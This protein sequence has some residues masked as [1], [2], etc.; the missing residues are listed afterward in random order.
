MSAGARAI[1]RENDTT[2]RKANARG[3]EPPPRPARSPVPAGPRVPARPRRP[4]PSGY[5]NRK[6]AAAEPP[7]L[8][9]LTYIAR[10]VPA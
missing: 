6:N 10:Q 7:P 2:W 4:D 1:R 5:L 8:S 9:N 3:G